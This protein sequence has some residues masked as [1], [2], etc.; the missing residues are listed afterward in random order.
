M[1]INKLLQKLSEELNLPDLRFSDDGV[2]SILI[3]DLFTVNIEKSID[4]MYVTFYG[5]LGTLPPIDREEHLLELATGNFFGFETEGSTLCVDQETEEIIL[6]KTLDARYMQFDEFLGEFQ[7]FIF[8]EKRWIE[9][10]EAKEYVYVPKR[11]LP[12]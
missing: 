11:I 9:H 5:V 2:A 12:Y 4:K 6:Y 10:M 8:V 1:D 3:N 7:K